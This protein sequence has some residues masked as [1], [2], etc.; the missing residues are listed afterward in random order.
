MHQ[1]YMDKVHVSY[2]KRA[3]QEKILE[4]MKEQIINGESQRRIVQEQ[5]ARDRYIQNKEIHDTLTD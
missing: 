2:E 1:L 4:V 3:K 5:L